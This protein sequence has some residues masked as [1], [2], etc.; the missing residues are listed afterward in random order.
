MF[1]G[2]IT[3]L[4]KLEKIEKTHYLFSAEKSFCQKLKKG[5]SVSINGICLTVEKVLNKNQFSVEA[6][7]ET[8]KRTNLGELKIGDFVNLELSLTPNSFLSGHFVQGHIDGT[9]EIIAIKPEKNSWIFKFKVK[10]NLAKYLI[11]KGAIAINGVSMTI[12]DVKKDSFSVGVIPYTW[13]KTIFQ[14]NKIE[15]KVNI[16]IDVLAK[17]IRKFIS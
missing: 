4:G 14:F 17:Y 1:T 13:K 10:K 2:I 7:P 6:M 16:E 3:H 12:I 15:D 9:A 11:E 5:T 8:L